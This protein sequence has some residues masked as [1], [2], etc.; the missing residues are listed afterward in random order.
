MTKRNEYFQGDSRSLKPVSLALVLFSTATSRANLTFNLIPEAGTPQFAIDGFNAAS[1]MWSS[2]L[3]DNITVNVQI[4]YASLGANVIGET[5]STFME[6]SYTEVAQA[7]LLHGTSADDASAY[8]A[9][10]PGS[11]YTRLIN[12]TSN[13]PNGAN[14][15]TP[16]LDSM[17]RVGLTTANA[18]ALG[19]LA[20]GLSIDATIRFSSDFSFD[21]NHG[22]TIAPGK[23]DFVGVAAH[24]LGHALGFVSGVDDIDTLGGLLAGDQFSSNLLDL[25]RYSHLSLSLGSGITDYTAD[26]RDKF[27]SVDG[28][29][30]ELALFSTGSVQGDGHQASHWKDN[31]GLGL[32]DPTAAFGERLDLSANDLRAYDVMGFTIIPEPAG[33]T[34]LTMGLALMLYRRARPLA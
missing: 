3:G 33:I 1:A 27:F 13:N 16:Y 26:N 9:L 12:H 5:S 23:M 6:S 30:T 10:P 25:F 18:K 17:N 2:V 7:L 34:L 14:S 19:L 32:M 15:P 4:G 28:G 8:A 31:L 11:S 20:A 29:L 21:F 22:T 24:E